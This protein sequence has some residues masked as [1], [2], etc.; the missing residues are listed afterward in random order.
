MLNLD[1]TKNFQQFLFILFLVK[2]KVHLFTKMSL[3]KPLRHSLKLLKISLTLI[4]PIIYPYHSQQ[5]FQ[6]PMNSTL[7]NINRQSPITTTTSRETTTDKLRNHHWQ[8]ATP[9][10][11]ITSLN[12]RHTHENPLPQTLKSP[13]FLAPNSKSPP[14]NSKNRLPQTQMHHRPLANSN[15]MTQMNDD[16]NFD[17][18]SPILIRWN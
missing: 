13:P 2:I 1:V 10:P 7:C 8:V 5:N 12:R 17:L 11:P 6:P 9:A 14:P 3:L 4:K 15:L 16:E 18:L